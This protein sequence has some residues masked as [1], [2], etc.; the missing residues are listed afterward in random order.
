MNL[1][2]VI[3]R[4][5]EN[6]GLQKKCRTALDELEWIQDKAKMQV[7]NA[8]MDI[9]KFQHTIQIIRYMRINTCRTGDF[10][11][12]DWEAWDSVSKALTRRIY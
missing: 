8:I 7:V 5:T 6:K 4:F 3:N 11:E 2:I 1:R 12:K 9:Y 10:E